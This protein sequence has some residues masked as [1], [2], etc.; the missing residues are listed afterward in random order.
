MWFVLGVQSSATVSGVEAMAAKEKGRGR[1]V[2]GIMAFSV[3]ESG[4]RKWC[5]YDE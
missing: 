3:A 4:L 1:R 2:A 5:V